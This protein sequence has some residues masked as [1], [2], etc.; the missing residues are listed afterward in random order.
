MD[1]GKVLQNGAILGCTGGGQT[2]GSVTV[3]AGELAIGFG[4][5]F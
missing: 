3:I 2:V 5:R 4:D 1:L